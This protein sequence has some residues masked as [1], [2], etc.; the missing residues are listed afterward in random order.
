MISTCKSFLKVFLASMGLLECPKPKRTLKDFFIPAK[1][2]CGFASWVSPYCRV[3]NEP[4]KI[5]YQSN[6]LNLNL[7]IF[8]GF[9]KILKIKQVQRTYIDHQWVWE[10]IQQFLSIFT[11]SVKIIAKPDGM[12]IWMTLPH[13]SVFSLLWN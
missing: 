5:L 6:V 4:K 12:K 11:S 7:F 13:T 9:M 2:V 1:H 8:N 3:W 10:N